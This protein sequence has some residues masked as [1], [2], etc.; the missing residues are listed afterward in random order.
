MPMTN[1][2]V[3]RLSVAPAVLP[4]GPGTGGE[5]TGTTIPKPLSSWGLPGSG[6]VDMLPEHTGDDSRRREEDDYDAN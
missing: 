1:I 4:A 6:P 5:T 3:K 2:E